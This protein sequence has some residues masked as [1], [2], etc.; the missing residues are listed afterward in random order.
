MDT[1]TDNMKR[2]TFK[3]LKRKINHEPLYKTI[4]DDAKVYL[5]IKEGY[6]Y[7]EIKDE[8]NDYIFRINFK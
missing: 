1:S 5:R 6:E 7:I 8:Y 2:I 4:P 3:E